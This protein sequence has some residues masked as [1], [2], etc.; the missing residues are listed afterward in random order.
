MYFIKNMLAVI[1]GKIP[2]KLIFNSVKP[3]IIH[4]F[5]HT[6]SDVYLPHIHP[7]YKPKNLKEFTKDID[8]L[9][10]HFE[11][12]DINSVYYYFKSGKKP[13]KNCFHL[14]FDDG[15]R[16]VYEIIY[17]LLL[18]KG[19]HAT[20]FINTAFV[21][22]KNLFFRHKAALLIDAINKKNKSGTVRSEIIKILSIPYSESEK[23]NEFAKILEVDFQEYLTKNRPYLTTEELKEMKNNGF[24]I[25][26]HSIDHPRY[27]EINETEQIRQTLESGKYI[28]DTFHES[29]SFFS[30]P[31]S[32]EKITN[33]FFNAINSETDLTFGISGMKTG[34]NGKHIGRI[35]MER[36]KTAKEIIQ[37]LLLKHKLL[38]VIS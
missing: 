21:D 1:T 23:F 2:S 32:D 17:P 4:P 22:N 16:E 25:G 6:V 8:F 5:Y 9:C 26:S 12:I 33:S 38:R 36:R 24:T 10:R 37:L 29:N 28:R 30:F 20:I 27:T 19:I 11:A 15:L 14:S 18:K 35:D 31:F 3:V 7:I 13:L 34:N